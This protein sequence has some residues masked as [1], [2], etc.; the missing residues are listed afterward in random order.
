VNRGVVLAIVFSVGWLPLHLFRAES[1]SAALPFYRPRERRWVHAII[2]LLIVHVS[3]ACLTLTLRAPPPLSRCVLAATTFVAGIGFWLWG[4]V[5][6]GPLRTP[7]LPNE[8]PH[9][10]RCDGA[11]GWVRHP[12]YFG[13]LVAASAPLIATLRVEIAVTFVLA[14]IAVVARAQQEEHRLRAQLGAQY[15]AYCAQVKRLIPFVW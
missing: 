3:A 1:V 4:R 10:L 7:R 12:L 9:A 14:A 8:P 6:I 2:A 5:L 15:D 11:F 13:V